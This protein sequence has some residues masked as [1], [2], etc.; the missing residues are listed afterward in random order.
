M[1]EVFEPQKTP[2][3]KKFK[4]NRIF[5]DKSKYRYFIMPHYSKI[6]D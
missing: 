5:L 4:K 3:Q 6:F 1:Q 2:P